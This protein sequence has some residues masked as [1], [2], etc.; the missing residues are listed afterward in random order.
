MEE[1]R[2]PSE[3]VLIID[4]ARTPIGDFGGSLSTIPAHELGAIADDRSPGAGRTYEVARS[5]KSSWAASAR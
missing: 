1:V 2:D 3:K 5:M 4:G